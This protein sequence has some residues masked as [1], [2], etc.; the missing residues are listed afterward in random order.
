M[1]G[2]KN[3]LFCDSVTGAKSSTNLYS[4]IETAK[5]NGIEPHAYHRLIF[6]ELHRRVRLKTLKRCCRS[7]A[8]TKKMQRRETRRPLT[9]NHQRGGVTG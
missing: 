7:T 3:F 5:A 4:L 6:T 9:L 8:I 1:H 2:R